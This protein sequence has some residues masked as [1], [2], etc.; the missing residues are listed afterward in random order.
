MALTKTSFEQFCQNY[1]NIRAGHINVTFGGTTA[2]TDGRS[3]INLPAL[4][5]DAAMDP[6]QVRVWSGYLDHEISHVKYTDD[7]KLS[8]EELLRFLENVMEDCRIETLMIRDFPGSKLYLDACTQHIEDVYHKADPPTTKGQLMLALFYQFIYEDLRKADVLFSSPVSLKDFPEMK[9]VLDLLSDELLSC[10]SSREVYDL[11]KRVLKLMPAADYNAPA[12]KPGD[13]DGATFNFMPGSMSSGQMAA[14]AAGAA[15][16]FMLLDKHEAA[17]G[18]ASAIAAGDNLNTVG[19]KSGGAWF[20][21]TD[22][23]GQILPPAS[24]A[25]DRI[26]VA[27]AGDMRVYDRLKASMTSDIEMMKRALRVAFRARFQS[28]WERGQPEGRLDNDS[29]Q[30]FAAGSTNLFKKKRTRTVE[31]AAIQVVCDLSG[32]MDA[33]KVQRSA[34]LLIEAVEGLR[35]VDMSIF[36]F[37]TGAKFTSPQRVGRTV[38]LE[39]PLIKDFGE[40]GRTPKER[41]SNLRTSGWTP[42]GEAYALAYGRMI[43][44]KEPRRIIWII[45]DGEP[46]LG[47]SENGHSETALMRRSYSKAHKAGIYVV[48]MNIGNLR[49]DEQTADAFITATQTTLASDVVHGLKGILL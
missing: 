9:P 37:T 29:L 11:A 42:L 28:A 43:E 35:N 48:K 4:P 25:H 46:S 16:L 23:G 15:T 10:R 31:K 5:E 20:K 19:D 7:Y 26:F 44:R 41:I 33:D 27:K 24:R 12:P 47:G 13:E 21:S 34:L 22:F 38:G 1:V 45:T 40:T 17:D 2:F 39:I 14:L 18:V 6:W 36:G 8:R 3:R 30:D 49:K 32:S